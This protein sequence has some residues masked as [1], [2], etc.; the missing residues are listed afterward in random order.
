MVQL[1]NFHLNQTNLK[2][3]PTNNV[4]CEYICDVND[5]TQTNA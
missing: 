3:Q 5:D 1:G 2:I 4:N